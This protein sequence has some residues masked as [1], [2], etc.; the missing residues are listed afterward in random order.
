MFCI[1]HTLEELCALL[2]LAVVGVIAVFLVT[3]KFTDKEKLKKARQQQVHPSMPT[4]AFNFDDEPK[5]ESKK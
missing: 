2:G 5:E 1:Y 4:G 3:R